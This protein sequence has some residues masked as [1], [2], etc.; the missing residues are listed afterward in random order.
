MGLGNIAEVLLGI[1]P[2]VF[3]ILIA[4]LAGFLLFFGGYLVQAR[5]DFVQGIIMMVGVAL[6]PAVCKVISMFYADS[7]L[8][9]GLVDKLMRQSPQFMVIATCCSMAMCFLVNVLTKNR[10]KPVEAQA[11]AA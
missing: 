3:M 1:P 2:T 11:A 10:V 8:V 7:T 5:A 4:A 9:P 6:I